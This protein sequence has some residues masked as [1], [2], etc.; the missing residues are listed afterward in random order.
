LYANGEGVRQDLVQAAELYGSAA[1]HGF[2][3]AQVKLA[4][5]YGT[6]KGV[7]K[8]LEEAVRLV[9]LAAEQGEPT[10]QYLLGNMYAEGEGIAADAIKAYAWCGTAAAGGITVAAQCVQAM[11]AVMDEAEKDQ[12]RRLTKEYRARYKPDDSGS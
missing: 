2:A 9:Q 7:V 8:N 3:A 10:A 5:M 6:G 4:K 12:A 1:E 11:A